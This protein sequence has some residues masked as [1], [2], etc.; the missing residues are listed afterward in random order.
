ML[1]NWQISNTLEKGLLKV[2][3]AVGF[4]QNRRQDS[5]D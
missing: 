1:A 3:R 2:A 4:T 5:V